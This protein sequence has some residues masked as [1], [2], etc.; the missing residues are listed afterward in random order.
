MLRN[1][2]LKCVPLYFQ[3]GIYWWYFSFCPASF[4]LL[5]WPAN[6]SFGL[7]T[8]PYQIN[9]F[10]LGGGKISKSKSGKK[11][12]KQVKKGES[13]SSTT[14]H[15][16]KTVSDSLKYPPQKGHVRSSYHNHF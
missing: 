16:T 3:M 10:C 5:S 6:K 13:Q 1:T 11:Q 2:A 14:G 7:F 8:K 4:S 9:F 15:H 12:V